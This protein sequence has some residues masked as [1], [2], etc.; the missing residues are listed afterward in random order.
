MNFTKLIQ[1]KQDSQILAVKLI[2]YLGLKYTAW[3]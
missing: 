2:S 3:H 1:T